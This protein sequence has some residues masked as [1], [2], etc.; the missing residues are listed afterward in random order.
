MHFGLPF[1][2]PLLSFTSLFAQTQPSPLAIQH[3]TGDFYIYTTYNY[4]KGDRIPANGMYVLTKQGA[5]IIDS[6]WDTTQFQPLLDSIRIRHGQKAVMCIA[7]HFHEDRTGGFE[8]YRQQGIKTY[9]T[10]LTDQL[11]QKRGMKRAE[12]L[13]T[14]DTVFTIGQYSFETF[15]P[16]HGHTPD[17]IV[18]WFANQKILYGGCLIKSTDDSTLGNLGDASVTDYATTLERVKAKCKN[19]AYIIPGHN[20]WTSTKSLAHSLRMAKALKSKSKIKQ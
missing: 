11:S 14:K 15:H 18:I 9:S 4:Y 19:P 5:I 16:G 6:P 13:L 10:T 2:L 8:Y 12:F 7:T 20:A 3:L 1:I 17:N